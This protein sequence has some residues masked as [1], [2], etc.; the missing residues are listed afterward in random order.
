MRWQYSRRRGRFSARPAAR[1]SRGHLAQSFPA[2]RAHRKT[3][4]PDA[5]SPPSAGHAPAPLRADFHSR[6][7]AAPASS[8]LLFTASRSSF[9]AAVSSPGE[10]TATEFD[11]GVGCLLLASLLISIAGEGVSAAA[12]PG[13]A[14]N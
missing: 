3:D 2:G 7:T 11:G 6:A 5:R 14:A 4:V 9:S 1:R 12:G 13:L 8:R 10:D